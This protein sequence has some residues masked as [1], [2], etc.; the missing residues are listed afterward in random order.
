MPKS[1]TSKAP[2]WISAGRRHPSSSLSK[3]GRQGPYTPTSAS[4]LDLSAVDPDAL[5][6]SRIMRGGH[7]TVVLAPDDVH[8]VEARGLG[9]R[10][11]PPVLL[12]G[13][14]LS[15]REPV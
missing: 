7:L 13:D 12:P 6:R 11:E 8:G 10:D 15:S 2:R 4:Y 5:T 1:R 9:P 14:D 3:V